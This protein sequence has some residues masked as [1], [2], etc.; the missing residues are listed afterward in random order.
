MGDLIE[1]QRGHDLPSPERVEGDV[2]IVG[3]FGVTGKHNVARYRGPGVAI[4]RSGASIGTATYVE[5][6]Y[7]PLNTCLFVSDFNGNDP[8]WVYRLLD[9]IDFAAFDSG[10]AQPSLNRNFLRKI[11]VAVPPLSEQRAIAEVLGA[12]D[13]KIAANRKLV[14]KCEELSSVSFARMIEDSTLTPLSQTADFV[15]GKAFTKGASGTGRVV[16]RIAEL[17]SG[18]GGST[19][20]S[21]IEVDEKHLATPGDILFAWSGSLTLHRWFR[22]EAIVNQHIFKVIPSDGYPAWLVYQLI[23]RKLQQFKDIAADKATTMGHIQRRHLDEPVDVPSHTA[24]AENNEL[25]FALWQ[26]ALS[27]EQESQTLA[28]TR[29]ALL[30]RLMSGELRVRDAE[31]EVEEVL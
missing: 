30:P 17:N 9:V 13:D 20:F 2:P 28:A 11:P 22:D 8:R 6:D 16:V 19:V 21:D 3:S 1:L 29:D 27:A 14:E 25:M 23:A 18:I 12:L 5:S 7:W 10:S 24:I 31:R 4:G 26:R 15:N